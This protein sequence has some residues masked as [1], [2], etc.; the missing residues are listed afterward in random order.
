MCV[1]VCVCVCVCLC[2]CVCVCECVRAR[3]RV[4]VSCVC[5]DHC[6]PAPQLRGEGAR[7]LGYVYK[8]QHR[9]PK[10]AVSPYPNIEPY[11]GTG[12]GTARQSPAWDS[13]E[14]P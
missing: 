6:C 1:C 2:V 4:C 10:K 9:G 13:A 3:V 11:R 14:P 8:A 12:T 7:G 5:E